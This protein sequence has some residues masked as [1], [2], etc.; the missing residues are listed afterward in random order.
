VTGLLVKSKAWEYENE[1]R[2]I[3]GKPGKVKFSPF[4]LKVVV[5]G[6]NMS[7]AN[8]QKIRKLLSGNEWNH[9][10]MNE[11]VREDGG[12]RLKVINC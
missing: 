6:L 10:Q 5:F 2:I 1:V 4:D 7:S 3:R 9:V 12:F 8:R 11:V